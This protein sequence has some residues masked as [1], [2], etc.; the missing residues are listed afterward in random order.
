MQPGP[1]HRFNVEIDN[2]QVFLELLSARNDFPVL[3]EDHAVAVKDQFILTADQIVVG[4]DD[5][6]VSRPGAQ[7]PFAPYPLPGVI[8]R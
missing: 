3:I 7:H 4:N 1:K 2:H 6:V 5:G 8:R